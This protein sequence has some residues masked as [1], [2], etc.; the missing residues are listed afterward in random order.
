[1]CQANDEPPA[2]PAL[3]DARRRRLLK[4][5]VAAIP[6]IF[7]R[8]AYLA[9]LHDRES[10]GEVDEFLLREHR[11]AF[12]AW[13]CLGLEE[14]AADLAEYL[15]HHLGNRP[16]SLRQ[17]MQEVPS[18]KLVPRGALP[19]QQELFRSDLELVLRV[20]HRDSR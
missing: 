11:E 20:F 6:S 1:M 12:E 10:G 18:T 14:Q 7:G 17:W 19:A 8:L 15:L 5:S 13:L 2:A 9:A 3:D 16:E 4:D